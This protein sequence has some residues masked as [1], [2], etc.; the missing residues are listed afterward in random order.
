MRRLST[1]TAL[2]ILVVSGMAYAA[3]AKTQEAWASGNLDRFDSAAKSVVVKQGTHEM[4]FVLAS[5]AH[6]MQGKTAIQPSDLSADVGKKIK[7]RYTA[8]GGT[9]V[10]DRIEIVEAGA[11]HTSKAKTKT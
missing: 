1:F 8:N 6:L 5:D 10:A 4:T 3:P 9:K 7:V 11:A 2:G